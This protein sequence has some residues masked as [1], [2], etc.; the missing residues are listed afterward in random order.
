MP[1]RKIA[2]YAITMEAERIHRVVRAPHVLGW[3]NE[4]YRVWAKK[5]S[6]AWGECFGSRSEYVIFACSEDLDE[7]RRKLE[8]DGMKNL[9]AFDNPAEV[10]FDEFNN[11][12]GGKTL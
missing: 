9:E 5:L 1:R 6:Y 10:D 2:L 3:S 4:D 8:K 11:I 12:I 7:V